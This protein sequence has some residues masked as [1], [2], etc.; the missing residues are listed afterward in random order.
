[1][2]E[3]SVI[4]S[5]H[6]QQFPS[7]KV[8]IVKD[9]SDV[10]PEHKKLKI[11]L[12]MSVINIPI[13]VLGEIEYNHIQTATNES[14]PDEHTPHFQAF[15][16]QNVGPEEPELLITGFIAAI[17]VEFHPL[18]Y[19][20]RKRISTEVFKLDFDISQPEVQYVK[21]GSTLNEKSSHLVKMARGDHCFLCS[22]SFLL[23]GNQYQHYKICQQLCDFI[24]SEDNLS[25]LRAFLGH[26][27]TGK[28]YVLS[29]KMRQ[30]GWA[31]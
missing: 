8:S 16:T 13:E 10:S 11:D 24:E 29:S 2:E 20:Q 12:N 19:V 30:Q 22:I 4:N 3:I 17:P 23:T 25:K 26:H 27:N 21:C 5:F 14:Q 18:N 28:D 15:T 7:S 9:E 6:H 31:T 1:M